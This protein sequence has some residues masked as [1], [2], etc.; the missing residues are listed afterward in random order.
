MKLNQFIK[1]FD[2]TAKKYGLG[3]FV[4]QQEM[5]LKARQEIFNL[6]DY[7]V[8]SSGAGSYFLVPIN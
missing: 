4:Y 6:T 7:K 5:S 1:T 3:F 8:S 2:L